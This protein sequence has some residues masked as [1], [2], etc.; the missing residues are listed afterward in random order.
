MK[1]ITITTKYYAENIDGERIFENIETRSFPLN[2]ILSAI[3]MLRVENSEVNAST[4]ADYIA[5]KVYGG[6]DDGFYV[7]WTAVVSFVR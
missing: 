5:N 1:E 3:K 4:I 7:E 2:Y 6:A